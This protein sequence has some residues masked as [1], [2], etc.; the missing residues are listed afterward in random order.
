MKIKKGQYDITNRKSKSC[1]QKITCAWEKPIFC[2]GFYLRKIH[3]SL[4]RVGDIAYSFAY[5]SDENSGLLG[6]L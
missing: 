3:P 1:F 6:K 2:A 4:D 5:R